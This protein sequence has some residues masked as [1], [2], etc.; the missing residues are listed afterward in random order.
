MCIKTF[1][2]HGLAELPAFRVAPIQALGQVAEVNLGVRLLRQSLGHLL[3]LMLRFVIHKLSY[4]VN[5]ELHTNSRGGELVDFA[6]TRDGRATIRF[7]IP[8]DRMLGSFAQQLAT[9]VG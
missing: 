9:T 4:R 6:V 3:L 1:L 2:L 5:L 8:P 7:R